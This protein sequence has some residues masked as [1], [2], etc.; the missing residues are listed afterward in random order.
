MKLELLK[1][2]K[3]NE[4]LLDFYRNEDD[5][6][7]M[8]VSQLAQALGYSS[9]GSLESLVSRNPRVKESEFSVVTKMQATDGKSYRTRVFTEDGIYEV[10]M[11]S[12]RPEADKFRGFVRKL[13]KGLRKGELEL[14]QTTKNTINPMEQA[15]LWAQNFEKS[16]AL[17]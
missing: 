11:L 15:R 8:T 13:L 6:I 3:F 12:K 1:Q 5:E 7:F 2:E 9:K 14:A 17:H 4:V 10:A 16:K